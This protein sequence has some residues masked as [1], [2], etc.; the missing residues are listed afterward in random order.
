MRDQKE[1]KAQYAEALKEVWR[2]QKMIDYC[3]KK[4]AY[5][6]PMDNGDIVEIEKP[7]IETRFCFG[8]G[9][10]GISSEEDRRRAASAEEYART[11]ENYFMEEN[12][13]GINERIEALESGKPIYKFV[14]YSGC[15]EDNKIKT[16]R[17]CRYLSQTPEYEPW[18]WSGLKGLAEITQEERENLING[19]KIVKEQF[20]KRL[21][22]YLKKY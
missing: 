13:K 14:N 16:I 21:R 10:C 15:G 4:A 1:L 11:N 22:T 6:V 3:I 2:D 8:Y 9:Y 19:Y 17:I 20:E 7:S 12:L 5:I 18:A